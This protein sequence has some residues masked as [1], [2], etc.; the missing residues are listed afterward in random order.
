MPRFTAGAAGSGGIGRTPDVACLGSA[1]RGFNR[2]SLGGPSFSPPRRE[3]V[4]QT[5]ARRRG[6]YPA[7]H[8]PRVIA[9]VARWVIC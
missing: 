7:R 9:P 3:A 8:S 2:D 5:R 6:P 4:Q 1:R